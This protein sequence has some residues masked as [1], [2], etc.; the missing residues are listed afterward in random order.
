MIEAT[1]KG[2]PG[3][4]VSNVVAT[5]DQHDGTGGFVALPTE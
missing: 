2:P 1:R 4:R 5:A 3:A